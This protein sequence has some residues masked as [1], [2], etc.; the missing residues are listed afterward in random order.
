ML[1]DTAIFLGATKARIIPTDLVPVQED[2][3]E[4]CRAPA[5]ESFGQCAN[6]PPY[7]MTSAE[8]RKWIRSFNK[9]LL[10]KYDLP[11]SELFGPSRIEPFRRMFV[12]VT[13]LEDISRHNGF[14]RCAALGAGS[15]KPVFCP[16]DTCS[17]L[18]G[19]QCR[20]PDLA[21]PSLEA[22]GINVFELADAVGW[23]L[24][25]ILRSTNPETV[26]FASLIG[27]VLLG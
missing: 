12:L 14:E 4:M 17:L 10:V 2:I 15:C 26:P 6:C 11:T 8:A 9:A 7:V 13:A 25:R 18:Q 24:N 5:C 21:R 16:K 23:P 1:V 20:Y 3:I 27:M 22:L 19:E